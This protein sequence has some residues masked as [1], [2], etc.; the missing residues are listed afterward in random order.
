MMGTL[1]AALAGRDIKTFANRYRAEVTGD[2]ADDNGVLKITRIHVHYLLKVPPAQQSA[3][4]E[5]FE[6]YLSGCPAAQSVIG[7]IRIE[8]ELT[9]AISDQPKTEKLRADC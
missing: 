7:C 9:L 3:A 6:G 5:A 1:A 8:H 2:I 4:K